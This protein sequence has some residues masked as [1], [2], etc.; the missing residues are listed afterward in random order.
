MVEIYWQNLAL[1][2]KR[3]LRQISSPPAPFPPCLNEK[4]MIN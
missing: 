3:D 1:V 4:E 2:H